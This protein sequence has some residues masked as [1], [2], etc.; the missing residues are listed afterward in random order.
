MQLNLF[1]WELIETGEGC[2]NL[3]RLEFAEAM[4]HFAQ[5]LVINPDHQGALR[6][7]EE[8]QFWEGSL[9]AADTLP[10]EKALVLLWERMSGF[11][12]SNSAYHLALRRSLL[13]RLLAILSGMNDGDVW[14][15]PPDL[16]RGVL[17]LQLDEHAEAERYFR[18][19]LRQ[20]PDNGLLHRYLGDALWGQGRQDAA[21]SEYAASLLLAPD[22]V[23]AETIPVP[24][25]RAIIMEQ[26]LALAPIY[27]YFA[28]L[29]PLVELETEPQT[30]AARACEY[31]RQAEL[32]RTQGHHQSMV[33]ARRTLKE[34]APEI[35]ADYLAWLERE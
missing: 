1:Q 12:F 16:C 27:G 6:G 32:A 29:L 19:L 25:L 20:C 13:R 21:R 35:L 10:P 3:G 33:A 7:R 17:H 9:V 28:S 24:G 4:R 8:T 22:T 34:H 5:A 31:L 11:P 30:D 2:Q 15:H 23:Y 26:G 18:T 14:Y